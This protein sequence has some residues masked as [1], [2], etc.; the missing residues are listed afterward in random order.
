M[1]GAHD[2]ASFSLALTVLVA[3]KSSFDAI[4]Q[5]SFLGRISE[6][7]EIDGIMQAANRSLLRFLWLVISGLD[8]VKVDGLS[9][10]TAFI[11]LR[12]RSSSDPDQTDKEAP[13]I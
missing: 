10:L 12:K 2:V 8:G 11:A 4:F 7:V 1:N 9:R 6:E 13:L 3:P 5:Q